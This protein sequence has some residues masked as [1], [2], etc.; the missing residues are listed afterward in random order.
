[1]GVKNLNKRV[2]LLRVSIILLV[3]LALFGILFNE[4]IPTNAE[5]VSVIIVH[6]NDLHGSI[7]EKEPEMGYA[8]IAAKVKKFKETNNNV[9]LL[10]A[11]DTFQGNSAASLSQGESIVKIMNSM[12]YDAMVVGNHDFSYGWQRL[13][14][15]SEMTNFPVLA[16]NV[17]REDGDHLLATSTIKELNGVRIG[18]FGLTTTET[19]QKTHPRNVAGLIF[20]DP[21]QTA[22]E[23]VEELR[24]NCD[25]II[26]LVHLPLIDTED[27]CAKLAE[28]VDGIDLIVSG[29]SHYKLE[30]GMMVNDT[31]IVQA[32][33]K[34]ESLGVVR[35]ELKDGD[36]K[37]I[38]ASLYTPNWKQGGLDTDFEVQSVINDINRE[39]EE[40]MLRVIGKTDV[41]LNG[42]REQVRVSQTNL[43]NLVAKAMLEATG[44]DGAI[45]NGGGIRTS[46]EAGEITRGDVVNV[47][48]FNNYVILKE[49]RGKDLVQALEHGVALYPEMSGRYPQVAGID[50]SFSA[51]KEPG[52]RLIKVTIGGLELDPERMYRIAINDFM[53]AGG[54][55][56]DVFEKA[57]SL[58]EYG[59]LVDIVTEYIQENFN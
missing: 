27:S 12:G 33:E 50:F 6:T 19:L 34:G 1:M 37:D 28:E 22:R 31:L 46:I 20:D 35:M 2:L 26:A 17:R 39:N 41:F 42:E 4:S 23:M 55:G 14:E 7:W 49:V 54:D 11:G 36:V 9:L 38:N 25:L 24:D 18:I 15:L 10:D 58:G 45:I 48:P 52:N 16:A 40:I 32:G 47:L 43:G 53:A 30:C 5:S 44:A 56:Y 29:H 59:Y 13:C 3:F 8:H 51:N 57:R 21:I